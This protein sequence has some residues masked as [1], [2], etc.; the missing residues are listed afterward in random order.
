MRDY[1]PKVIGVQSF[2]DQI[3]PYRGYDPT[4][5]ASASN[6]FATA[7]F[8]FG[9]GTIPPILSRLNESFQEH[10]RFPHL[11]LHQSF[12]SPWRIVKEGQCAPVKYT[13]ETLGEGILEERENV[14]FRSAGASG[15]AEHHSCKVKT[16][17]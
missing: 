1:V 12:F 2:E 9:H 15:M 3:G 8:R 4:V 14:V 11:R 6:V 5:D 13:L 7:A 16:P 17:N 10:Q